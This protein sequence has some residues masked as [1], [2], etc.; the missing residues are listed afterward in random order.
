MSI[1]YSNKSIY[2]YDSPEQFIND[3]ESKNDF[4]EVNKESL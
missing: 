1:V 3:V 2:L 4:N